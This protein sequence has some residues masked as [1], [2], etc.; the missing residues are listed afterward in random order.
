MLKLLS[1]PVAPE[2][3]VPT[4]EEIARITAILA[5]TEPGGRFEVRLARRVGQLHAA[6]G[7]EL[8]ATLEAI[9]DAFAKDPNSRAE[10]VS[11]LVGQAW[12]ADVL[13]DCGGAE[14]LTGLV[15]AEQLQAHVLMD[16][17]NQMLN[18][19]VAEVLMDRS[20]RPGGLRDLKT[21][22]SLAL[23]RALLANH[24]IARTPWGRLGESRLGV[25]VRPSDGDVEAAVSHTR[26]WL[27]RWR[28]DLD[29]TAWTEPVPVGS[30]DRGLLLGDIAM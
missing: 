9:H 24:V 28:G 19:L 18:M 29:V 20:G 26:H 17:D 8:Q 27:M 22:L 21:E 5:L 10:R 30:L 2:E 15:S 4:G 13:A 23:V 3:I 16:R 12:A 25:A 11:A 1:N 7:N 6:A 14:A